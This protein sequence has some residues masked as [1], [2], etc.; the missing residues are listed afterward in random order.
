[1]NRRPTAGL[2]I[3]VYPIGEPGRVKIKVSN[4]GPEKLTAEEAQ[5]L[6]LQSIEVVEDLDEIPDWL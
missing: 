6:L 4:L 1:M 5:I 2:R 3:E